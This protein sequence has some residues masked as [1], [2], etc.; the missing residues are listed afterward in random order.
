VP[1]GP[2]AAFP[3]MY[4]VPGP[5]ARIRTN[6]KS[7]MWHYVLDTYH[8]FGIL[9]VTQIKGDVPMTT[10]T[11]EQWLVSVDLNH[12]D[13]QKLTSSMTDTTVKLKQELEESTKDPILVKMD[14]RRY[15][16]YEEL[17][18]RL[19]DAW[20]TLTFDTRGG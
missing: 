1:A 4:P 5:V 19:F 12:D 6:T 16:D 10:V 11:T 3:Y 18:K 15:A 9:L 2:Q 7:T 8:R 20:R 14:Q 17:Q 13:L